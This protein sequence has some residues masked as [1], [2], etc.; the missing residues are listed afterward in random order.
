M[1]REVNDGRKVKGSYIL[2]GCGS[3]ALR[4]LRPLRLNKTPIIAHFGS[5]NPNFFHPSVINDAAMYEFVK[6]LGCTERMTNCPFAI[7]SPHSAFRTSPRRSRAKTGPHSA[8]LRPIGPIRSSELSQKPG[9]CYVTDQTHHNALFSK[10]HKRSKKN[11][12]EPL[13]K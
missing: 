5:Q 8:F 13:K 3:A 2:V 1:A 4:S 11:I 7:L 9:R 6:K 10:K 12:K